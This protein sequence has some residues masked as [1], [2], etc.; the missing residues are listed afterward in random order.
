MYS[1]ILTTRIEFQFFGEVS[2]DAD[3]LRKLGG[4]S[5]LINRRSKPN[6]RSLFLLILPSLIACAER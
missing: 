3:E 2:G 1:R 5:G 4:R 6:S